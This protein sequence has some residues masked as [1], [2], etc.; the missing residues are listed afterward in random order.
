M[1]QTGVDIYSMYP[2]IVQLKKIAWIIFSLILQLKYYEVYS[3]KLL[4]PYHVFND[5]AYIT[6]IFF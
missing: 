1:A 3:A 4:K 5:R 6:H 2:T